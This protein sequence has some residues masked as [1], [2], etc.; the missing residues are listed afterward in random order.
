MCQENIKIQCEIE[1]NDNREV[2]DKIIDLII[3]SEMPS[4]VMWI[5]PVCA[6]LQYRLC[7]IKT[8]LLL[9]SQR[10]DLKLC[11]LDAERLLEQLNQTG[12]NM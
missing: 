7:E 11:A 4:A 6:E 1:K 2:T 9:F 3:D 8:K 5:T 10:K 12:D